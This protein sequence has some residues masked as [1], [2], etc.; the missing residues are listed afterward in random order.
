MFIHSVILLLTTAIVE[1]HY[2]MLQPLPF[3]L[4]PCPESS[5]LGHERTANGRRNSCT[6]TFDFFREMIIR[7][8]SATN[9][10]LHFTIVMIETVQYA[11]HFVYAFIQQCITQRRCM[12]GLCSLQITFAGD[13][14]ANNMINIWH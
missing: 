8:R 10:S 12:K 9:T 3:A 4:G 14:Q 2:G 13:N 6:R 5:R 11:T 7:I 1:L